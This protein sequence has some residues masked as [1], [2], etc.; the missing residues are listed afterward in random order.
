MTSR[1]IGTAAASRPRTLLTL[2]LSSLLAVSVTSDARAQEGTATVE[3]RVESDGQPLPGAEVRAGAARA[4]TDD[5]GRARLRLAPGPHTIT[6]QLLGYARASRRIDVAAGSDTVVVIV[7]RE[8]AVHG[9]AII[10]LST[11]TGRR[12]EDEP[13]R[14]EVIG[15]E[16]IE[17]KMLMT[18]GDISMMLN[19]TSGL[20]VQVTSPSMGGAGVRIQGLRGRYTQLLADGLPL[21]GGQS[22]AL[23]MLQIPPMDL[24]QVEVIKGVASALYG[25]SALGGVVNLI[26]RSPVDDRELLLNRT[27]RGGTDAVLWMSDVLSP[28]WGYTLLSGGHAQQMHDVDGDG[29]ADLP[30][31][32]RAVVRPRVFWDDGA[33]RSAFVTVGVMAENREGGTLGGGTTP[34][35]AAYREAL[36]TRRLDGGLVARAQVRGDR[37]LTVRTSATLQRHGHRFGELTEQDVHSTGFGELSLTGTDRGHS[38]VIGGALQHEGYENRDVPRFDHTRTTPSL[39]VQDEVMPTPRVTIAASARLD[40]HGDHGAVFNPRLSV[41]VAEEDDWTV[42]ASLGTGHFVPSPFIE[43][44]EVIGLSRL[45]PLGALALERARSASLDVGRHAGHVELNAT[46]FGSEVTNPLMLRRAGGMVELFNA[47][48]PTR[49]WGAD[50]LGRFHEGPFH[51]TAT[52]THTRSTEHDP[53]TE[54]RR[55]SPL[56]PRHAAGLVGMWEAADAGRA[57]IEFYYVGRQ[58]LEANPY[59]RV[60]PAYVILGLLLERRVGPASVFLNAENLLDSRQTRR[61]PLL[62]PARMADGRWTTDVW[63]PLD[64]RTVNA[65]LRVDF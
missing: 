50:L 60:G 23:G 41:L 40:V 4:V 55:A 43:E 35:G 52:Y 18:P 33:G 21:Y 6:A 22:G 59:R 31:Y 54:A 44:T 20:R 5:A 14:V 13:L 42:R 61:D 2:A 11:R 8:E 63:A 17:E 64:G 57:G 36:D 37:L 1:A 26:S 51:A 24:A 28:R 62:L 56:T 16:E 58:Q 32:R 27:S 3:I 45:Q 7:L 49:T 19:E 38:W 47:T 46:I 12:V 9:E 30:G 53:D 34:E 48:E 65:G 29:W 15:R 39:F 25:G 10:V